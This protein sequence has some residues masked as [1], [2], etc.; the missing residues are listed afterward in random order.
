MEKSDAID[1]IRGIL[2]KIVIPSDRHEN[3]GFNPATAPPKKIIEE[4]RKFGRSHAQPCLVYRCVVLCSISDF[5]LQALFYA[6]NFS[7]TYDI[8]KWGQASYVDH[9]AGYKSD[10]DKRVSN[11]CW[12][13]ETLPQQLHAMTRTLVI[14]LEL[15]E[16]ARGEPGGLLEQLVKSR[17]DHWAKIGR[18]HS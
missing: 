12:E 2:E 8:Y 3:G 14:L 18:R 1:E 17:R 15:V 4:V 10:F 11:F 16:R 6:H 7:V 13:G 5:C 9:R